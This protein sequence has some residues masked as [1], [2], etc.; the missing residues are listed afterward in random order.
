MAS[1]ARPERPALGTDGPWADE[2]VLAAEEPGLGAIAT[3]AQ[4]T[5][6]RRRA[7][8][9][10]RREQSSTRRIWPSHRRPSNSAL[11]GVVRTRRGRATAMTGRPVLGVSTRQCPWPS[12]TG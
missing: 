11:S 7:D 10:R 1:A 3:T 4:Y 2:V 5:R 6:P 9:A 8:A 12:N